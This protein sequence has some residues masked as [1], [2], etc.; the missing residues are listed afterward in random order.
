MKQTRTQGVLQKVEGLGND[1]KEFQLVTLSP[2]PLWRLLRV[3][4]PLT[5]QNS[6][7]KGME[8]FSTLCT[9]CD[10]H[11][12]RMEWVQFVSSKD[13]ASSCCPFCVMQNM[14]MHAPTC[15]TKPVHSSKGKVPSQSEFSQ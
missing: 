12:G 2:H 11:P 5:S 14:E 4:H 9:S 1:S 15:L 13:V 8:H 3:Y 10:D 6:S 7:H